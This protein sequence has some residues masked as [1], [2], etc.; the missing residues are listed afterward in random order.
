MKD[1]QCNG[2]KENKTLHRKLNIEQKEPHWK[3]IYLNQ[4]KTRG[5]Q[6]TIIAH[7]LENGSVTN[8][9]KSSP[10]KDHFSSNFIAEDFDVNFC[11]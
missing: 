2:Q 10:T 1:A 3:L 8:N 7:V 4:H 5:S 9:F 11:S 6:E